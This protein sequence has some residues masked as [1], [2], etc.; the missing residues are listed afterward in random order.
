MDLYSFANG[1]P[2]NYLDPTGR[3]DTPATD[4]GHVN[5]TENPDAPDVIQRFFAAIG[6]GTTESY[7]AFNTTMRQAWEGLQSARAATA[8]PSVTPSQEAA[9]K[10]VASW[11]QTWT[12]YTLNKIANGEIGVLVYYSDGVVNNDVDGDDHQRVGLNIE[13]DDRVAI[14]FY[15][16]ADKASVKR[17]D[18]TADAT[19]NSRSENGISDGSKT[20]IYSASG[21]YYASNNLESNSRLNGKFDVIIMQSHSNGKGVYWNGNG[22]SVRPNLNSF[23]DPDW[24]GIVNSLK[25][26]GILVLYQ[27][28]LADYNYA[29]Q[30]ANQWNINILA[31]HG[32]ADTTS[33][34]LGSSEPTFSPH[35]LSERGINEWRLI[36]PQ[37]KP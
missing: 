5:A 6:I 22:V 15:N 27:C 26:S 3:C 32:L 35:D 28:Y 29:Q 36:T 1:D 31:P 33:V 7:T 12:L 16:Q 37:P 18:K 20:Y 9:L 21:L 14:I 30:L 2:I 19:A 8:N 4:A 13:K 17:W 34:K 25:P 10:T 24:S 11:G 23:N